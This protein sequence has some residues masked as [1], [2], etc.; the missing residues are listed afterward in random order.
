MRDIR[1]NIQLQPLVALHKKT[2]VW[3]AQETSFLKYSIVDRK[4]TNT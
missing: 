4:A 2:S 3:I 1:L